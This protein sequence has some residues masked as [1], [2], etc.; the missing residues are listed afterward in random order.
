VDSG[1]G[2]GAGTS[3]HPA[4]AGSEHYERELKRYER[5]Y[6]RVRG[7]CSRLAS[8]NRTIGEELRQRKARQA[9]LEGELAT[10]RRKAKQQADTIADMREHRD[11]ANAAAAKAQETQQLQEGVM[12]RLRLRLKEVCDALE[13]SNGE[14]RQLR[15]N[16]GALTDETAALRALELDSRELRQ[17]LDAAERVASDHAAAH[18]QAEREKEA[19]ID[20]AQERKQEAE[21]CATQ[22]AAA[23]EDAERRADQLRTAQDTATEAR[24]NAAV[25]Q[26]LVQSAEARA[27]AAEAAANSVMA[28]EGEAERKYKAKALAVG[29]MEG[30]QGELL[31]TI[32]DQ[33]RELLQLR[34]RIKLVEQGAAPD[35]LG[36]AEDDLLLG[37]AA[38]A[39]ERERRSFSDGEADS[40]DAGYGDDDVALLSPSR[41][42]VREQKRVRSQ[43]RKARIAAKKSGTPSSKLKSASRRTTKLA[44]SAKGKSRRASSVPPRSATRKRK[45]AGASAKSRQRT[46]VSAARKATRW[47]VG[48]GASGSD[49]EG[50]THARLGAAAPT[51]ASLAREAATADGERDTRAHRGPSGA[52]VN[53][54]SPPVTSRAGTRDLNAA[55]VEATAEHERTIRDMKQEHARLKI[56]LGKVQTELADLTVEATELRTFKQRVEQVEAANAEVLAREAGLHGASPG[57]HGAH[58]S[59][60]GSSSSDGD[61][62]SGDED[63]HTADAATRTPAFSSGGAKK[64]GRTA[65]R[66]HRHSRKHRSRHKEHQSA[67]HK[68]SHRRNHHHKSRSRKH[69]TERKE[70]EA[71]SGEA[72]SVASPQVGD[73]DHKGLGIRGARALLDNRS[74]W[75]QSRQFHAA[76]PNTAALTSQVF[77]AVRMA[78]HVRVA[79]AAAVAACDDRVASEAASSR[80]AVA[81]ARA[82]AAASREAVKAAE[83]DT[84]AARGEL[85]TLRERA[86]VMGLA[87]AESVANLESAKLAAAKQ[88]ASMAAWAESS[89]SQ[90]VTVES[91]QAELTAETTKYKAIAE[92]LKQELGSV[93][94]QLESKVSECDRQKVNIAGAAE[95]CSALMA[96]AQAARS[97]RAELQARVQ[98]L[99]TV[100]A[101]LG[102]SMMKAER[103]LA[104]MTQECERLRGLLCK[105]EREVATT[106]NVRLQ[107]AGGS[108]ATSNWNVP[109]VECSKEGG[110][111]KWEEG[112]S[113]ASATGSL[114]AEPT[115]ATPTRTVAT[116]TADAVVGAG[117]RAHTSPAHPPVGAGAS[118]HD[119][120]S[121]PWFPAPRAGTVAT[122]A[123][124]ALV[125]SAGSAHTIPVATTTYGVALQSESV[126][127]SHNTVAT[128]VMS[129]ATASNTAPPAAFAAVPRVHRVTRHAGGESLASALVQPAAVGEDIAATHRSTEHT[130]GVA[131]E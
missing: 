34:T 113:A 104:A 16:A 96:E 118:H 31:R 93:R 71:K 8:T 49:S 42:R 121:A 98:H 66:K 60:D 90:R 74:N 29:E 32:S 100:T 123:A 33:A 5:Q 77:S 23:R 11:D 126:T 87:Q 27:Q 129:T 14:N 102:A 22:L 91:K 56:A 62:S 17:R 3:V 55:I 44:S 52:D 122:S 127:A 72:W 57:A 40:I 86:R 117:F 46:P 112:H 68:S 20:F 36:G 24:A 79:A 89:E 103:K 73:E 26:S 119:A 35:V 48:E 125:P 41:A 47:Q 94:A 2:R 6:T 128:T 4:I 39:R 120:A 59:D 92:Q 78:A 12:L 107:E 28:R 61:V 67:H 50:D 19:L 1:D 15:D 84:A 124:S 101:Q 109:A 9:E 10:L 65:K 13:A 110:H 7:E 69:H 80:E 70:G 30:I 64:A 38:H 18:A 130:A 21:T 131:T 58:G 111:I 81:R 53:L 76:L 88:A 63:T 105:R 108:I 106:M 97:D 45:V 83:A 51:K 114:A 99:K 54:R 37:T 82:E 75:T 95:R 116:A 115:T 43:A 25:A 85:E